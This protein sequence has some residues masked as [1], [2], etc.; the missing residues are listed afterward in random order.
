MCVCGVVGGGRGGRVHIYN[1][2]L[3][4]GVQGVRDAF[5]TEEKHGT[6]RE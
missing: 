3:S 1:L 6:E 2:C 4:E 5:L